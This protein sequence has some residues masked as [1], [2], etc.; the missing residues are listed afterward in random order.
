MRGLA[1]GFAFVLL[2]TRLNGKT[3]CS[4]Y[5]H[6]NLWSEKPRIEDTFAVGFGVYQGDMICVSWDRRWFPNDQRIPAP[7]DLNTGVFHH[8]KIDLCLNGNYSLVTIE[9][10]PNI[11]DA[12]N[13]NPVTVVENL[14][15]D[16]NNLPGFDELL[17]YE[18]RIE[19]IGR[20]GGLT[21][22][23]DI[24]N[25]R[26][27]YRNECLKC[28]APEYADWVAWCKPKC[29]CYRRQCRGDSDGRKIGPFWVQMLDLNALVAAFNKT[30]TMLPPGGIC[31][32]YDHKKVGPFRVQM[33][34]LN[35]F[36]KY[37]NKI[38][39]LVPECDKTNYNF[40]VTP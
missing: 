27:L 30:D 7:F 6:S 20:N 28:S 24:D 13:G 17:P 8:A 25:I 39:T 18:S 14:N 4:Q 22:D 31:S 34:D 38:E 9:L 33:L 16:V 1:D 35:I 5:S 36:V 19:F 10:T 26:V 3:G 32:D 23:A 11:Y 12:N 40:W 37:F 2:P 21:M 29:W 15:I